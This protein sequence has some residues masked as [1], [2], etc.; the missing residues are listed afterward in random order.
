MDLSIQFLRKFR[1]PPA[2][3]QAQNNP[4]QVSGQIYHL[5][6]VLSKIG[7]YGLCMACMHQNLQRKLTTLE[8]S[9][10]LET[11]ALIHLERI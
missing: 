6:P 10:T 1:P 5:Y 2:L 9:M 7:S 8:F 4:N 3:P 11:V